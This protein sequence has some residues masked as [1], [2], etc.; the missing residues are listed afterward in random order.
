M[1]I[2]LAGQP[3]CGKST[4]FNAVAGYKA[5]TG[6]FPGTTTE[7]ASSRVRWGREFELFDLASAADR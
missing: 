1:R 6:N 3:N 4:M 5:E 7:Y 2:V